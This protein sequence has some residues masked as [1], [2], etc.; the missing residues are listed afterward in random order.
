MKDD[1]DIVEAAL[2]LCNSLLSHSFYVSSLLKAKRPSNNSEPSPSKRRFSKSQ[3]N[4]LDPERDH[5]NSLPDAET[6]ETQEAK[7]LLMVKMETSG[8]PLNWNVIKKLMAET[9]CSQRTDIIDQ[10]SME[11]LLPRWPFIG[12]VCSVCL[13]LQNILFHDKVQQLMY[14]LFYSMLSFKLTLKISKT[15][16]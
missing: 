4:G 8:M 2:A 9:Y 16:M 10:L 15:L 6:L 11:K 7:R 1:A 3:S 13:W 12:K 5:P 14:H